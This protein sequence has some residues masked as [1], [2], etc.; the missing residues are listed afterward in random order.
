MAR[1]DLD[2]ELPLSDT[3]CRALVSVPGSRD[4]FLKAS[5]PESNDIQLRGQMHGPYRD[6]IRSSLLNPPEREQLSSQ[7][8]IDHEFDGAP[9]GKGIGRDAVFNG[10]RRGSGKQIFRKCGSC[11]HGEAPDARPRT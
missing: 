8:V 7:S 11:G 10:E 1:H 2:D 6:R 4:P 9:P 3:N 5:G